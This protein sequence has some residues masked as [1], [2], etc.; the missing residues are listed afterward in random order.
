MSK[1]KICVVGASNIDLISY[2][3]RYPKLGETITGTNFHM[4]FGGKGANQ[5]VMAAKLG[6]DVSIVTKVGE[7]IFGDDTR[8][9]FES[10]G[11]DTRTVYT[12]DQSYT[13]VAPIWVE[14]ASGNNAI[15][16]ALGANDLLDANDIEQAKD[17]IESAD[18]LVCQWELLLETVLVALKIG[19]NAGVTTVF[20]PAPARSKLPDEVFHNTDIFCPN[21]TETELL[22]G[23]PVGTLALAEKAG[24]TFLARGAGQAI[25][26]LGERG[27]LLI[28][29]DRT[30][31]V[32]TEKVQAVDTTGA[33]DSFVGSLAF[34][35]AGGAD[36]VDAMRRASRI[37]AISV[38][39]SGTQTSFPSADELPSDLL[40]GFS[41]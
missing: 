17:E 24:K 26:T 2:A 7:D 27:S 28:A 30:V 23:M 8:K 34:F 36:I 9:N 14:E 11:M 39:A 16:V 37:A 15:I 22:T 29:P 1:P 38:Q 12:T 20:N 35:L 13:G 32:P 10:F 33:G 5:A 25:I 3:P 31:H 18:I 40:D 6:G 4:G 19:H 41:S 21:E